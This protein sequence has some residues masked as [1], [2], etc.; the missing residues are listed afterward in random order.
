MVPG[1][2]P[3]IGH[4]PL[5]SKSQATHHLFGAMADKHGPLFT[6]KLGT[7]TTLVINNW[8]TAKDCY[9][10]NDIAVSYRPN[11]VACKHMTYNYAM[12][13]F[14]PYGPFWREM[15]KIVT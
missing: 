11:L 8:E 5:L 15:R 1:A 13:G 14:A 7:A 10:T 9:K 12:V 3:I 4:F 6:I 2:W